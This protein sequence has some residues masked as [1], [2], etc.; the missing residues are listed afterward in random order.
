MGKVMKDKTQDGQGCGE[1][2]GGE[3]ELC[4]STC[5]ELG[6]E[7]WRGQSCAIHWEPSSGTGKAALQGLRGAGG[8]CAVHFHNSSLPSGKLLRAQAL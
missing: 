3:L 7:F 6:G 2:L 1:A 8:H 5:V 4:G